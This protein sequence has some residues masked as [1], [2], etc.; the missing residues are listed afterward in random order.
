MHVSDAEANGK[1]ASGTCCKV[2]T[3]SMGVPL[4][5]EAE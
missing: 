1:E 2:D 4:N 5:P 3:T